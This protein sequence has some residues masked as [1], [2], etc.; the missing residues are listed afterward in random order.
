MNIEVENNLNLDKYTNRLNNLS[1][2]FINTGKIAKKEQIRNF[3][4]GGGIIGSKWQKRKHPS[5]H[6]L[7]NKTGRLKSG[8]KTKP[9]KD[10]IEVYNIVDYGIFHQR[11]TR[12]MPRRQIL[13]LNQI[14]QRQ[15]VKEVSKYVTG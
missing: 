14:I 7:L 2:A 4:A 12:H 15:A 8:Y 6:P 10:G 13:G 1:P 11:G 5:N 9:V 3:N